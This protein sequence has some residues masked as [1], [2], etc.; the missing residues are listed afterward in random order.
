V[1][2]RGYG[3][4]GIASL[5][6]ESLQTRFDAAAKTTAPD[7]AESAKVLRVRVAGRGWRDSRIGEIIS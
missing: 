5:K 3:H 1:R 7:P 2:E 4:Y 6:G